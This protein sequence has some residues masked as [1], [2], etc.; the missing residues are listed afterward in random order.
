[1]LHSNNKAHEALQVLDHALKI[2]PKNN[3][4][5]FKR[6]SVLAALEQY[7]VLHRVEHDFQLLK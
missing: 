2:D 1:V 7:E 6:A 5:R 3:L 4:A